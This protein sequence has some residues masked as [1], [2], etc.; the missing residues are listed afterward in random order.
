MLSFFECLIIVRQS[1]EE[2]RFQSPGGS[3]EKDEVDDAHSVEELGIL[4]LVTITHCD[5]RTDALAKN[6]TA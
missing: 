1:G 6:W 4:K 2:L 5:H 3:R